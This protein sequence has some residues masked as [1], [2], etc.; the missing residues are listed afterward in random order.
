MC[1]YI[2]ICI[3]RE[4][5]GERHFFIYT[6]IDSFRD[7]TTIE[8]DIGTLPQIVIPWLVFWCYV[9]VW[10]GEF[11]YRVRVALLTA[12]KF[13]K[14]LQM[15]IASNIRAIEECSTQLGTVLM[16]CMWASKQVT[17]HQLPAPRVWLST[18]TG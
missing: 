18:D 13:Y 3:Y 9:L 15:R 4:K 17:F 7:R 11:N 16:H 5:E 12:K 8:V 6:H 2:Y 14:L 10:P 1:I